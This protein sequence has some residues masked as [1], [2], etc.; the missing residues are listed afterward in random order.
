MLEIVKLALRI[1]TDAFDTEIQLL[2]D[3]CI[4]EMEA[5]GVHVYDMGFNDPQLQSAVIA[6]CKWRFGDSENKEQFERI[7]HTK[8]AQFQMMYIAG[9][10]EDGQEP[11]Y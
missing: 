7:Y 11:C 3:D 5:L 9:Y 6:Y 10:A 8:L 2:I 4:S 1:I